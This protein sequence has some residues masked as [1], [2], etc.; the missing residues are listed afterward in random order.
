MFVLFIGLSVPALNAA[1]AG[2]WGGAAAWGGPA[3]FVLGVEVFV[4][5][6]LPRLMGRDPYENWR[7]GEG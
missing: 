3:G 7:D 4:A 6:A 5:K 2:N 1:G